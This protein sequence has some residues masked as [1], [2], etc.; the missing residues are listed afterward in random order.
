VVGAGSVVDGVVVP[1]AT[2]VV[3]STNVV[4]GTVDSTA[5]V[6]D[7]VVVDCVVVEFVVV[8]FVVVDGVG[9]TTVEMEGRGSPP[10][11]APGTAASL[12]GSTPQAPNSTMTALPNPTFRRHLTPTACPTGALRCR[13]APKSGRIRLTA[14]DLDRFSGRIGR[15]VPFDEFMRDALYGEAGFYTKPNGGHA[16][17]RGDFLTSPEVGPLFGAVVANYLDAVWKRIGEPADF[18]VVDVGAGPGT[19]ARSIAAARPLCSDAMRFIAVELSAGQ[20]ARHPAE[21]ESTATMPTQPFDG[22][23]IANELL[24]N[25][26]FRLAVFDNGWRE[27]YIDR[28]A[29]GRRTETLSA[30]FDPMPAQL[31]ATAML[32]ARVPLI[33]Q[34]REWVQAARRLVRNGTVLA[35]DYGVPLTAE[36]AQR[37]WRDWLRTY[38]GN[39][40]GEHYLSK[41]GSQDITTDIPFDQLPEPDAL[42]SQAQ[43][44]QRWG[45]EELVDEGK[46]IWQEQAAR[47]GLEAMKMRS[48]VSESE[49]LLDPSGLGSFLVAEWVAERRA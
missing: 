9:S 44:L 21:I 46:R 7:C 40:R 24:D 15:V 2:V 27:A 22:V 31:L 39:E 14:A 43:F 30:P 48:R 1:G 38:R 4:A 6:V 10:G 16:G 34:A 41:P 29:A 17:R 28:D 25:L 23:I 36:L 32:G 8:E 42:R 37:P 5:S 35:I 19:L 12:A 3:D 45:I 18:T 26:P 47:P 33:E 11:G 20:R 13:R 49:A